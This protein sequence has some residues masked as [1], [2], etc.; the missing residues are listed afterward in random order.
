MCVVR[1]R[2]DEDIQRRCD[3]WKGGDVALELLCRHIS[4]YLMRLHMYILDIE[5]A[6]V[7]HS[8]TAAAEHAYCACMS[9]HVYEF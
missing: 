8:Y 1:Y 5:H 9:E 7:A 6:S 3:V 2:C 4:T